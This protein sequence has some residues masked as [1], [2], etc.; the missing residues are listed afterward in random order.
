MGDD[1]KK[2]IFSLLLSTAVVTSDSLFAMDPPPPAY[3]NGSVVAKGRRP[4]ALLPK[5]EEVTICYKQYISKKPPNNENDSLFEKVGGYFA[6]EYDAFFNT[7]AP[8]KEYANSKDILIIGKSLG[9]DFDSHGSVTKGIAELTKLTELTINMFTKLTLPPE[10]GN[11]PN[12]TSLT[13]CNNHLTDLPQ[14]LGNLYNLKELSLE[15]NDIANLPESIGKLSNLT[16]LHLSENN[17]TDLPKSL[18]NLSKLED[19]LLNGNKL[20]TL[21]SKIINLPQLEFIILRNNKFE[22]LPIELFKKDN[23]AAH[24]NPL[25]GYELQWTYYGMDTLPTHNPFPIYKKVYEKYELPSEQNCYPYQRFPGS[26]CD[27]RPLSRP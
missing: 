18:G 3:Q 6:Q 1:M 8:Q 20:S 22:K 14:S 24:D 11:L 21:S 27:F 12:L 13:L 25:K 5:G 2:I 7:S 16:S 9:D 19:L 10:I 26:L 17:L 15:K 4:A 23:W